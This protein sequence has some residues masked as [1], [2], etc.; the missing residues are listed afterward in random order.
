MNSLVG[1]ETTQLHYANLFLK[2]PE[3]RRRK[4]QART[5]IPSHHVL[6]LGLNID[7]YMAVRRNWASAKDMSV[8]C[9]VQRRNYYLY[10]KF[11]GIRKKLLTDSNNFTLYKLAILIML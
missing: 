1:L 3:N 2:N 4:K 7:F 5:R 10:S 9:A 11:T 8:F 6:G